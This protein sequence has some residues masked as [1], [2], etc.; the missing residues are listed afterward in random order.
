MVRKTTALATQQIFDLLR[1]Q[2]P[3]VCVVGR[4]ASSAAS[5]AHTTLLSLPLSAG[6]RPVYQQ[7]FIKIKLGSCCML[8]EIDESDTLFSA[9]LSVQTTLIL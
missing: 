2:W 4:M 8:E 6:Q 3:C 1:L 5:R 9:E 7:I